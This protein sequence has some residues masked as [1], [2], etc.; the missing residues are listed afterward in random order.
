LNL[1]EAIVLGI[2]QGLT[3]F[4]P[5]SS[6]GHLV[7]GQYFLGI[8]EPQLFFDIMLHI[9]TLGAVI[10]TFCRDI[11]YIIISLFGI[12]PKPQHD[13]TYTITK[14]YGRMFTLYIIVASIPTVIIAFIL[15]KSI[16]GLF[17]NPLFVSCML[18]ITGTILWLSGKFHKNIAKNGS[19]NFTSS[20][21]I[22]TVQGIAALPGISRSGS[23]ISAAVICGVDRN[24]AARYSLL[25]S[26]PAIIGAALL[27]F[28]DMESI[29]IPVFTVI[30][31][32]LVAFVVGYIAIKLLLRVLRKGNFSKFAYYCWIL[33]LIGILGYL[34]LSVKMAVNQV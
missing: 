15:S 27:D 14:K 10:L 20:L 6:S 24:E 23:T 34:I 30:C 28:K 13:Q 1:W 11:W 19:L 22:G 12:E 26:I 29:E 8:R 4:L 25:L 17:A 3:E 2:V 18:L 21:I 32:T 33:G 7:L 5:V 16:E 31:G 9:G